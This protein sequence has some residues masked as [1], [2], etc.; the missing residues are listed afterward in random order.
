MI[1]IIIATG[2]NPDFHGLDE[3]LPI[4]M[5][6]L[7][8]RPFLQHVIEFVARQNVTRFEFVLSH[9]PE[10]VE[11]WLGD[12]ARWGCKF[13][14]HLTPPGDGALN[15]ARNIAGG[16]DDDVLLGC[17][18]QLPDFEI[19]TTPFHTVLYNDSGDWTGWGVFARG[20]PLVLDDARHVPAPRCLS[21][22]TGREFL[23]S[24]RDAL[25]GKF[26]GLMIAGRQVEP[27]IWIS[28]NVSLHPTA[29]VTAPVYIGENCSIGRGAR[30]GPSAV[31]GEN[32]IVDTQST[33]VDSLVVAGT[34]IGEALELDSVI[35]DRNRLVNVRLGTSFLAS[36]TF[37]LSSLTVRASGRALQR[38]VSRLCAFLMLAVLWPLLAAMAIF[39][40]IGKRGRFASY[41]A[42]DI[43]ADD[44]PAAW[45]CFRVPY[46]EWEG[47]QPEGRGA[48][49]LYRFLPG[50]LSVLSGDLFLIGV[51]PRS[52]ASLEALPADWKSIYLRAKTGLITEAAVMFGPH[53][54]NDE[55]YTAEAYYSATES[56]SH[57]LKLLRLWA[58]KLVAGQSTA[59]HLAGDSHSS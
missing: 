38:T 3:H 57:D 35:V 59:V 23:R 53:C 22:R 41:E 52:R 6:P 11:A 25:A 12:G 17:G 18:E 2:Q 1:A 29:Q 19:A 27:G 48:E 42:V 44:N 32:C 49:F 58:W 46:I 15:L 5:L 21:I 20:A 45:R 37:L 26:P 40:A 28:R 14:Y 10:K 7:A 31:I 9:L 24:Q 50:L 34:Y 16:L 56:L 13:H 47:G 33:A 43:P 55:L 30:L 39:L 51:S 36:E 4:D 54:S 8:D